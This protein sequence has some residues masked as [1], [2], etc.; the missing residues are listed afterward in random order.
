MTPRMF[1]GTTYADGQVAQAFSFDGINDG[2]QV[3]DSDSL[4]LTE[5]MTIEAWILVDTPADPGRNHPVSR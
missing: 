3:A 2:A 4:K 5:S 1:N